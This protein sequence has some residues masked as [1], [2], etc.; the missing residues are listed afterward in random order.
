LTTRYAPSGPC[1]GLRALVQELLA[2]GA[3]P[4][5]IEAELERVREELR[6]AGREDTED[7]VLDVMD[8][9]TGWCS[10]HMKISRE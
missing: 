7:A 6:T 9:L 1:S 10:P 2:Q 4:A 3:D 5:S 8:F